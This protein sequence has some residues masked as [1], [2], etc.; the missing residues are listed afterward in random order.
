MS[1]KLKLDVF[2]GHIEI[3]DWIEFDGEKLIGM[4]MEKWIDKD[5]SVIKC[6]IKP[7]GVE[8]RYV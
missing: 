4:A 6:E 2:Y 5:G 8:A 7:T 3:M 1:D